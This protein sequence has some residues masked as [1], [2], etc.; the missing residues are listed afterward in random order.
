MNQSAAKIA[1][2]FLSAV[3]DGNPPDESELIAALDQLLYN[4]HSVPFADCA[5]IDLD[6]P[7][8]DYPELFKAVS[9]RFPALGYYPV[10][11]P[12]ETIDDEQTL[13]DAIDDIADITNDLREVIWRDE[14][15]GADDAAWYFRL[16]YFH[17]GNHARRLSMYL[18]ARQHG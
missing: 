10:V 1:H 6:P 4:S 7:D 8:R 11:D 3:W 17:W 2:H 13:A 5:E 14:N 16:M 18:H 9:V 15:L 12:L